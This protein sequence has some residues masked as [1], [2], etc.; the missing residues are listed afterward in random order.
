MINF[1]A[2]GSTSEQSE[3]TV[4]FSA[5]THSRLG[6]GERGGQ[7]ISVHGFVKD[8]A[9]LSSDGPVRPQLMR[10]LKMTQIAGQFYK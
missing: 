5:K 7:A 3:L 10:T 8:E 6:A 2:P 1:K 9:E 4:T